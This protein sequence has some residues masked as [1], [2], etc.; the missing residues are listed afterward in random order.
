MGKN[1]DNS[2]HVHDILQDLYNKYDIMPGLSKRLLDLPLAEK[3]PIK[4]FVSEERLAL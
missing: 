2:E 4:I 1:K 3:T